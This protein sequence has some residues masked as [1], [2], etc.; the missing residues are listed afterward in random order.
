MVP[1]LA[2]LQIVQEEVDRFLFRIVKGPDFGKESLDRIRSLVAERF[3]PGVRYECEYVDCILPERSG[4]YR[5][6]VS[7][8]EN[9]FMATPAR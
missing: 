6:C 8:V 4:K 3:G 1:G 5:F 9:P 2:Q 7:K